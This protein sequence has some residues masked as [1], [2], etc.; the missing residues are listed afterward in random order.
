MTS[1][2]VS[3]VGARVPAPPAPAAVARSFPS[4]TEAQRDWRDF[5]PERVTVAPYS[6]LPVTF[7][8]T[9]LRDEGRY[10]TW[11]GRNPALPGASF[12]GVATAQGY[13]AILILPGAGEFSFHVRGDAVVVNEAAPGDDSC[14]VDP[15]QPSKTSVPT[16][17]GTIQ[18]ITYAPGHEPLPDAYA[19]TA[20]LKVDVL[21]GYDAE[22]LAAA[23][24]KSTDPA[25]YIDGQCKAIIE[26]ANVALAQSGVTAFAWRYLGLVT[27]PTTFTR[28]GKSLDDILAMRPSGALGT[29]ISDLHYQRGA[30][31]IVLLLGGEMDYGG[32]GESTAQQRAVQ[33]GFGNVVVRWNQSVR[34]VA[35]ELAHNFGCQHDRAHTTVLNP[36]EYGP[37]SPDN[38]GFFGYGQMWN[39]PPIP[40]GADPGTSGTIMSYAD[41]RI[42]YFSNPNVSVH[43]SGLLVGWSWDPDLGTWQIG[44]AETDPKAAFNVRVLNEQA[45]AMSNQAEEI[46]LPAITEQ[47]LPD[48]VQRGRTINLSVKAT[49]GGLSYQWTKGGVAI[50][51]ATTSFYGKVADDADTGDYAVKISNLAGSVTSNSVTITVTAPAPV[52]VPSTS[53]SS[54]GGGGG[55]PS[56]GFAGLLMLLSFGRWVARRRN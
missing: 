53:S 19:E 34:S 56:P 25:G 42:P 33:K 46:L 32:R 41:Y 26:S 11:I 10:V 40:G 20:P 47:P 45:L 7:T 51:G 15:V 22:A 44:R 8:R 14:G 37:P 24:A 35:H 5:R 2:A 29:W 39:N 23:A 38:D 27:V 3:T 31:Q 43:V 4:I 54:G 28:T 48:A 55:A 49:G 9:A 36:G 17:I 52:V 21:F 16:S 18:A 13:D 6:D 1:V 30:D 50:S 12:V